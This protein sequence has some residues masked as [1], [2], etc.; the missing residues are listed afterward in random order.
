MHTLNVRSPAYIYITCVTQAKAFLGN[1][2][3]FTTSQKIINTGFHLLAHAQS[4]CGSGPG[5]PVDHL[6]V[7]QQNF[8]AFLKFLL[9]DALLG[10]APNTSFHLMSG[11]VAMESGTFC[12]QSIL[13]YQKS[14]HKTIAS[15]V[16]YSAHLL[17]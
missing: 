15:F 12:K 16:T 1:T 2:Y 9:W 11:L 3:I 4:F 14:C 5:T 10:R 13:R 8:L 17:P 7:V 6:C